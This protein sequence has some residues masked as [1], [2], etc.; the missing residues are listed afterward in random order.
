MAEAFAPF[1]R[2]LIP[3]SNRPSATSLEGFPAT[4]PGTPELEP[5]GEPLR[6]WDL[7]RDILWP[8]SPGTRTETKQGQETTCPFCR[9]P[10]LSGR[11]PQ[12]EAR[13]TGTQWEKIVIDRG[14]AKKAP[15]LEQEIAEGKEEWAAWNKLRRYD[16]KGVALRRVS[17][18]SLVRWLEQH[19]DVLAQILQQSAP[20]LDEPGLD[21]L[22]ANAVVRF[23]PGACKPPQIR[24]IIAGGVRVTFDWVA[25]IVS[26]MDRDSELDLDVLDEL[27]VCILFEFCLRWCKARHWC[28]ADEHFRGR[29]VDHQ[30]AVQKPRRRVH[31]SELRESSAQE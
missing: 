14:P 3:K 30:V 6:L 16:F 1:L 24:K 28:F 10:A 17:H 4:L 21:D 15:K 27:A 22:T 25:P 12:C 11:C 26:A 7:L 8:L 5:E 20:G 18:G 29:C 13:W 19:L 2:S 31:L 23:G 9:V